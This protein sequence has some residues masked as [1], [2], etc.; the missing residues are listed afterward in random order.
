[1]NQNEQ[2]PY[3]IGEPAEMF[4]MGAWRTGKIIAGY[5]YKDGI[6]TIETDEGKKIWCGESRKDLYRPCRGT[7]C[8]TWRMKNTC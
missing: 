4:Y 3:K 6:V 2:F 8:S 1:M 5:R 7:G